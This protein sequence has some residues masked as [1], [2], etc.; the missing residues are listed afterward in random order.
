M[1]SKEIDPA[2]F[3]H[4]GVPTVTIFGRVDLWSLQH[5]DLAVR[6]TVSELGKH[7]FHI[8]TLAI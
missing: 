8:A 4:I 6:I 5:G 1:F 3:W 2:C 7:S